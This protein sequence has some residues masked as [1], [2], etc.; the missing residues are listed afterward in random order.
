[1]PVGS[2]LASLI[3]DDQGE[4]RRV[5]SRHQDVTRPEAAD[6]G[7]GHLAVEDYVDGASAD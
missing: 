5:Q 3:G 1:M 6:V 2:R 4:V 7:M